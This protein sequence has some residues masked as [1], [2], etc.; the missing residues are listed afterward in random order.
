MY[1]ELS[2]QYDPREFENEIYQNWLKKGYFKSKPDSDKPPY[3]I[4]IP[5][6]N[7]T[8]IL[9]MGHVL[10]NTIQDILIRYHR[11][12]GYE[13]CWIP[14]TDH[15]S[16]ATEAKVVKMLKEQGIDKY[17]I[18]REEFLK[19]AQDWKDKYGGII[20]SQ[21]KKLGTSCDWD[22]ERFTM[23]DG[24][25]KAVIHA[26]VK[27]YKKDLI[28]KGHRLVNWCP[29][30]KS[31]IS[32]EEVY[33][34]EDDGHLWHFKY[35]L[36]DDPARFM[37]VATTRPE[38]MLGDTAVAV[39]PADERYK[40]LVGKTVMLPLVDREI[41]VIA[42]DY[43]D[44]EFGTGAV[45]ITPA[46]DP[47][48]YEMGKRHG[49][50]MINILRDDASLNE[51][52]PTKYQGLD[53]Y[54]A[55]EMIVQDMKEL[56]FLEKVE[57]HVHNVGYS[58][59]GHVPIEPYLSDQWYMKMSDLVKPAV[60]AVKNGD[61]QFYPERWE[62]TYFHWLDNIRDWCISRQLWWGH[63]IPVWSCECGFEDAY[64]AAPEKCPKC[65]GAMV[66]ESDVLD[67]WASSWLWPFAVHNWP[68]MDEELKY[69]YPTNTLVTAPEIIFFW[70]ARMI[71]AG[72]EFM[73]EIPFEKV[74]F[75]GIIRDQ[76]GRK[77]SKSL[78]NSP[79]PLDVIDE[80]GADSIRYTIIRLAPMGND[81]M[82]SNENCEL[83]KNFANKIWNASRFILQNAE[84]V[85]IK[86]MDEVQLE[87]VDKWILTRYNETV[88]K[89]RTEIEEF[90]FNDS[91]ISLYDFIWGEFCAWYLEISKEAIY[92]GSDAEKEAR[93][94]VLLHVLEGSLKMLHPVM[95]FITE[96][97]Y[98]SL[99]IHDE[100]I[101]ISDYP[102][103]DEKFV[104][105]SN[106][107]EIEWFKNFIYTVRNIRG[108]NTIPPHVKVRVRV[109]CDEN[110]KAELLNG[111]SKIAVRLAKMESLSAGVGLSKEKTD[112]AG[113]GHGFEAF[114]SLEGIIDFDK[115]R[116]K[117]SGE[118][119][120]LE[121]LIKGTNSKLSNENFVSRAPENVVARERE[122]LQSFESELQK[123]K[124]NLDALG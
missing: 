110:S 72:F 97:I 102:V 33:Y 103:Y 74:Y 16:I 38:T 91:T 35:P 43:V 1:S 28:Y 36:K 93:I 56:G 59:R 7:V 51:N 40:D 111:L 120:R 71:I 69:Y 105:E 54:E 50:E 63:R 55:R 14:G 6:P 81:I 34:Q 94:A 61:I 5:P 104:F 92:E 106:A 117:L 3:T 49:L 73:G 13:A 2:G 88:S 79:D 32:D 39:N 18:G 108:E 64:E 19:H 22:R 47:N 21:L 124:K 20:I 82:Y 80:F 121:G 53:R 62:K 70:V 4:V 86:P 112:A 85:A 101:M 67:T 84:G 83:G 26:F 11:M 58:E 60:K 12:N 100:S 68:E 24:Y 113:V 37:I 95:P 46:H 52:V 99:P 17:E 41:P 57:K 25:Y 96:R 118:I 45:K 116:E 66:Q 90:R 114:V 76:L 119:K 89:V 42:D 78:G 107:A 31:A 77:M 29:V 98:L 27:L 75:T 8:G 87:A 10:N 9:H 30:S 48:D 123:L 65:G 15:A 44:M 115:E 23:D 122:K 109:S